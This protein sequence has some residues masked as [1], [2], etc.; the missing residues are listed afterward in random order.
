MKF[1]DYKFDPKVKQGLEDMGFRR[2]TDIQYKSIRNIMNGEDLLAVAQTGT[3]KTAAFA[4]P[5]IDMIYRKK[6]NR[7]GV[8]HVTGLVMVP[9]HELA[10]QIEKVF[11]ALAKHTD[12]VTIALYGGVDQSPQIDALKKGAD[13]VIATP[14]RMFDL[15]HQGYLETERIEI[16]VLDEADYMLDLGFKK[17]IIDILRKLPN[18]RQTMFFSAT[19]NDKIKKIAYN[20]VKQSAIRIQIS[21]KDP[22]ARNIEHFVMY[23]EMDDKRFFLER[24]I[25][26]NPESKILA[27]VRTKVRAE[28]VHKAME[29]VNIPSLTIHGDKT[30][31]QRTEVL[32]QFREGETNL[33]IGTDVTARGIDI[34][35]ITIVINYDLPDEAENYVH[36]VGRTG[37]AKKKGH[38]YSFCSKEERPMLEEIQSFLKEE[39]EVLQIDKLEYSNTLNIEREKKY[40]Y[41]ALIDDINNFE[42][43]K[44]KKKRKKK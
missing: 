1:E 11:N 32:R 23:V 13:I 43:T 8:N 36:R 28:R 12:I 44:K 18:R 41:K 20:I 34:P 3:G 42:A 33:L 17:D 5:M 24:V 2:P 31:E 7:K 19:I 38:A 26:E 6:K 40:D 37:R 16:L 4:I 35:D 9:S 15:I 39:I 21:P 30:Q 29:R 22:V 10:I 27:F 14:G 25:N